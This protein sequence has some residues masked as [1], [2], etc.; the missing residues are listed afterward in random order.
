M[1]NLFDFQRFGKYVSLELTYNKQLF[2]YGLG[3]IISMI[4]VGLYSIRALNESPI[5]EGDLTALLIFIYV[6]LGT[7]IINRAF[8]AFRSQKRLITFLTFPVSQFEKFLFEY[9]STVLIGVFVLP[10]V[11]LFAYMTEGEL[12]KIINP[13]IG[14]TG[15]DIVTNITKEIFIGSEHEVYIK[16]LLATIVCLIPFSIMN[17]IFTGNS[18]FTKWPLIKSVLFVAAFLTFHGFL[19]YT[20]FEKMGVGEYITNE[21][22]LFFFSTSEAALLFV[23]FYILVANA[24]IVYSSYLKLTEKEL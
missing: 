12:H 6:V 15:L 9:L 24:V 17:L 10:L 14:Y 7:V 13:G 16:K 23:I 2:Y 22:P 19:V 5:T 8:A 1:N 20:I 18:V 21:N 3:A 4:I 11:I